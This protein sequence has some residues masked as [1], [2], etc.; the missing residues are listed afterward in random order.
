MMRFIASIIFVSCSSS[1]FTL[2]LKERLIQ[3]GYS[4]TQSERILKFSP[5]SVIDELEASD[6]SGFIPVEVCRGIDVPM[7]SYDPQFIGPLKRIKDQYYHAL[8]TSKNLDACIGFSRN[9]LVLKFKIPISFLLYPCSE[10]ACVFDREKASDDRAFIT[11]I[12]IFSNEKLI[13]KKFD[14]TFESK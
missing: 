13:W 10:W 7:A 4:N 6:N 14:D 11:E 9:V 12:G 1:A 5:S 8:W 3:A 2:N